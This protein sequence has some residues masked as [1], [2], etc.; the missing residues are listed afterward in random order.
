RIMFRD[1]TFYPKGSGI[2][3]WGKEF[4]REAMSSENGK[5]VLIDVK[6]MSLRSRKEFYDMRKIEFPDAPIIASHV[7]IAGCSIYKIPIHSVIFRKRLFK[8]MKERQRYK[9]KYYKLPGLLNT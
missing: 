5:R 9:V 2:T 1:K 4:I 8:I 3:K 7:G 6:H